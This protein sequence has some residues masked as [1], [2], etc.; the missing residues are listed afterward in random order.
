MNTV[1]EFIKKQVYRISS[2]NSVEHSLKQVFTPGLVDEALEIVPPS[3]L[4]EFLSAELEDSPYRLLHDIGSALNLPVLEKL[5]APDD[6]LILRS[7]YTNQQL[8]ALCIVPQSSRIAPAGFA[9]VVA[10]PSVLDVTEFRSAGVQIFLGL[11]KDIQTAW[12]KFLKPEQGNT[13]QIAEAQLIEVLLRLARDAAT[14]GANEVFVGHPEPE[15]YE[16]IA[17]DKRYSGSLHPQLFPLVFAYFSES[18]RVGFETGYPDLPFLK[19]SLTRNFEGPVIC[20]T[21]ELGNP[22]QTQQANQREAEPKIISE[23][24]KA[25]PEAKPKQSLMSNSQLKQTGPKQTEKRILVIEDDLRFSEILKQVLESKGWQVHCEA[26][27]FDALSLLQ[28]KT[29]KPDV[30]ICDVHMPKLD[31]PSFIAELR[32]L[33]FK[34]PIIILTSDDNHL[35]EAEVALLGADAFV[36]KDEDPRILL[37]W[38]RNLASK[39]SRKEEKSLQAKTNSQG[40]GNTKPHLKGTRPA[41]LSSQ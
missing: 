10:D 3:E 39:Y 27:G 21:W 8:R 36:R 6:E 20:L 11:G 22:Y 34:L 7:G 12:S 17:N 32:N 31:G 4:I 29:F 2:A 25:S 33:G 28:A 23:S 13:S 1:I 41:E 19:L 5:Q 35:I 40:K 38:C 16:F 24:V 30:I 14:L 26:N 9:L 15:H 18:T 37:A